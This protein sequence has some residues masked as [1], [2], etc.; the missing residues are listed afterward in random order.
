[1]SGTAS[2]CSFN[3]NGDNTASTNS[4]SS[5]GTTYSSSS[6]RTSASAARSSYDPR[7]ASFNLIMKERDVAEALIALGGK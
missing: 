2:A 3:L 7:L 5:T 4:T 6:R 1:M